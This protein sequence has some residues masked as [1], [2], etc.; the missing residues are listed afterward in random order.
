MPRSAIAGSCGTSIFSFLRNLHTVLHSGY[1]NL[2]SHQECRRVPFPPLSLQYLLCADF[3]VIAILS[4]VPQLPFLNCVCLCSSSTKPFC[5]HTLAQPTAAP[6]PTSETASFEI[7]KF[8]LYYK[9]LNLHHTA[10]EE[11]WLG[12]PSL[13]RAFWWHA[14]TPAPGPWWAVSEHRLIQTPR[15]GL[16]G[17]DSVSNSS[18][19]G[20]HYSP[21]EAIFRWRFQLSWEAL[22]TPTVCLSTTLLDNSYSKW[23]HISLHALSI[24]HVQY[25]VIH[26]SSR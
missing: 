19:V 7:W 12:F 22:S 25:T 2:R 23:M 17:K 13:T 24:L 18:D 16:M 9:Q 15:E 3:L 20:K 6:L 4:S 8:F 11:Y 1:S 5:E 21:R 14:P 10:H 26:S